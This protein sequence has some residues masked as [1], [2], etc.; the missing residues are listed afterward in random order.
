MGPNS[1][2]MLL[3]GIMIN[4]DGKDNDLFLPLTFEVRDRDGNK[5]S[6]IT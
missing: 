2:L 6:L 4:V 3:G 1:K 5:N